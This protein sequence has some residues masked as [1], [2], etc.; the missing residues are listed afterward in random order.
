MGVAMVRAAESRRPDRLFDDPYAEVFLAAAPG[1]VEAAARAAA[2]ARAAGAM[3]G[4]ADTMMTNV[5]VRTRFYDDYLTAAA[6]RDDIRQFVLLAAGL[7]SRAYRLP[8]P[9]DVRVFEVDLPEMLAF[10][11]RV[12]AGTGAVAACQRHAVAADLREDWPGPLLGAGFRPAET[13]CWLVEGLLIYLSAEQ[14]AALL[15]TVGDLSAPG[16]RLAFE[17]EELAADPTREQARRSAAMARVVAMWRGGLPDP[18]G[19]LAAHGWQADV[20][21]RA[22]VGAGYGR[23]GTASSHGG[24]VTAVRAP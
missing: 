5:V 20:H 16:S 17:F 24:F 11:Q 2:T 4:W 9:A 13:T 21:D 12:L 10:K 1:A 15:G 23:A 6:G 3:P 8:W 22:E 14:A 7:D 19:W 18:A